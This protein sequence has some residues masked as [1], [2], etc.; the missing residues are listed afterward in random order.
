MKDLSKF[1]FE[2][3]WLMAMIIIT[4]IGVSLLEGVT[5]A[6]IFPLLQAIKGGAP[7]KV[8]MV[9]KY[10]GSI[11]LE[12]DLVIRFRWVAL[13]MVV[14]TI[15]KGVMSYYNGVNSFKLQIKTIKRYRMLCFDQLMQ[16][17][18][19]YI[20]QGRQSHFQTVAVTMT[21]QLGVLVKTI[22]LLVPKIFTILILVTMLA[23]ISWKMMLLSFCLAG[24]ASLLLF[25][26]V[27]QSEIIGK[28][29]TGVIKDV[30]NVVWDSL[31]GMKV[32]RLFCREEKATAVYSSTVDR[33]NDN[34]LA[35][36]KVRSAMQPIF[37]VIGV[38]CLAVIFLVGS[39]LFVDSHGQRLEVVLVFSLI[40]LRLMPSFL[41]LNQARVDIKSIMPSVNEV[42][43]FI[44]RDDK[45]YVVS[46]S[47]KAQ[48]NQSIIFNQV[49]FKYQPALS[50]VLSDVSF[51]VEK[52]FKVGIVG[53]SGSG[54][55]TIAELIL[56]F[57][58][59]TVGS[60]SVDGKNLTALDLKA[61][62]RTIGVVSQ[63]V[64]LFNDTIKANIAFANP[65]ASTEDIIQAAK[66]AHAHE[67]ITALPQ[68]YDTLVGDRGVLLSGGQRQRLAIARAIINEPAILVFDEATSA[69][70]TTSEKI[71]QQTLDDIGQHKTVFT[72]A[73]RLSTVMDSDLIIVI[74]AGRIVEQGKHQELLGKQGFYYQLVKM[75]DLEQHTG[76]AT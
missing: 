24:L 69:L 27:K 7:D 45:N 38:M 48:F 75:Q 51:S 5:V 9:L 26:L 65:E 71:V 21:E 19:G 68:G 56:R 33:Y 13:A 67:F 62:R 14:T 2:Q 6:L 4:G 20:Q 37:E 15:I 22:G 28:S 29:F 55:S 41:A 8:P 76:L 57:Y 49:S 66:R 61:W 11:F 25:A 43:S 31:L 17:S 34:L 30:T 1:L 18:L 32:I 47:E 63:D 39:F 16:V 53:S 44:N 54:K 73:H 50:L 64:F 40:F 46:G 60:I 52:G 74:D 36:T 23:M 72:I 70:D 3:R 42:F 58:D 10:I 59:P 12:G 35:L